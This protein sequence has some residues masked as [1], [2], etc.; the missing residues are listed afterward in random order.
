M[1]S[2]TSVNIQPAEILTIPRS[3][4]VHRYRLIKHTKLNFYIDV[5]K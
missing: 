1:I 3:E 2:D 4:T 5:S